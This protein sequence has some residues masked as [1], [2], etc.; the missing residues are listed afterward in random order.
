M[1]P[2]SGYV[3]MEGVKP[4]ATAILT[5]TKNYPVAVFTATAAYYY[6]DNI[7]QLGAGAIG[8][9]VL[10]IGGYTL[11]ESGQTRNVKRKFNNLI[12]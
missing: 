8:L 10:A 3:W 2:S 7:K 11:Y 1:L 9:V 6:K 5:T 12:K 4:V